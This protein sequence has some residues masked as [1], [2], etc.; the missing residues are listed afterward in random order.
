VSAADF[1]EDVNHDPIVILDGLTKNWRYPGFRVSWTIGP[2]PIIEA[3]TS[4]GSFLEGGCSRPMQLAALPLVDVDVADAEARAI[5][6]VFG[7]KR[8]RVLSTLAELQIGAHA[9][10][11]GFYV[12]ADLSRLP[13]PLN[14]GMGLFEKGLQRGLITVPG[15]FFDINPGQ[16]RPERASRFAN[17]ARFSFGP[18]SAEVER[19]LAILRDLIERG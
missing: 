9:P 18:P 7:A 11:G 4:A 6:Q 3:I 13:E 14:T 5:Q 2:Q 10:L 19:G 12:W 15:V 8:D 1:V 16:R 17:F